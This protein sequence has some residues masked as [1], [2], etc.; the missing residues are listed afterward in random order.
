MKTVVINICE[1]SHSNIKLA[2]RMSC[3]NVNS[4][5]INMTVIERYKTILR[6]PKNITNLV[7]RLPVNFV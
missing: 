4:K 7:Y 5:V 1:L 6:N 3:V 2:F